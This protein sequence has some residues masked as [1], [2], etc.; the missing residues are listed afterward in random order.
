MALVPLVSLAAFTVP[1][2]PSGFV[3]DFANVLS[4]ADRATL[5]S[6]LSGFSASTTIEIAVVT[7]PS[8]DGDT[9]ETA[10][11][12]IFDS[13]KIGKE[14]KDNG[15]LVLVAPNEH[16]AR[17]QT[18]YGMEGALTDLQSS[19][20]IK[21]DMIPKFKEGYY[22]A[23]LNA[24]VDRIISAVQ[25]EAVPFNTPS[26]G[27]S[28]D[29]YT[30]AIIGVIVIRVLALALGRSKSWWMGGVLG[31][32]AGVVIIFLEGLLAGGIATV[33]L[34]IL[35]FL[36]DLIVS[37]NYDKL[38]S[39]GRGFWGGGGSSGGRSGGGFGG[40]GGGRSGGGGASGSW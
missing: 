26:E 36:F 40:F 6:R 18:G 14:G 3:N 25:G 20:I 12:A 11:N 38:K 24:G 31:G 39:G 13:W 32:I 4:S 7:V 34:V 29:I 21:N 22:Y 27:Q 15:V 37:K 28:F 19:W 23:G 30:I 35:G 1:A 17:I 33:I 10:A 5:E 2:Q 9:I 8:L 16:Q